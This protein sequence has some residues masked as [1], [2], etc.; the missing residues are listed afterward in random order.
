MSTTIDWDSH[1][2]TDCF[3]VSL[4]DYIIILEKSDFFTVFK[5]SEN[6]LLVDL[7]KV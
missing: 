1:D 6:K 2:S 7:Q 4:T 5:C 3:I